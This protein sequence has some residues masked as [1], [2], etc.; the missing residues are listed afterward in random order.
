MSIRP[1]TTIVKD[2]N[3]EN[4]L[5]WDW[6]DYL[7]GNAQIASDSFIVSTISGDAAPL[8]SDNESSSTTSA[9]HRLTGGTLGKTYQVTHRIVTN[10]TPA[11]TEDR[12]IKIAIRSL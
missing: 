4:V 12:S 7:V 1:G 5:T 3:A 2:P 11:Q 8:V 9:T 10:E 6:S